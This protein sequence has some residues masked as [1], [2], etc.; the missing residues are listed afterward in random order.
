VSAPRYRRLLA[1][2]AGALGALTASGCSHG[3]EVTA[4]RSPPPTTA[5]PSPTPDRVAIAKQDI[6]S[7]YRATF[8]DMNAAVERGNHADPALGRHAI[9]QA[10]ILLSAGAEWYIEQGT[11]PKGVPKTTIKFTSLN[12][13]TS[14]MSA[15]FTS[16]VDSS[17]VSNVARTTGRVA[18]AYFARPT[19]DTVIARLWRGRW[20]I[21]GI[22]SGTKSCA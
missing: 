21:E 9:G 22:K 18:S 14:P 7:A 10:K 5:S 19:L 20:V 2:S 4:N 16:C 6:V 12:L 3:A 13:Y 11:I 15:N 8:A 1:T 17:T